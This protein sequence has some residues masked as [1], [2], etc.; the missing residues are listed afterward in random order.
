MN[1]FKTLKIPAALLLTAG[2]VSAT[3]SVAKAD[4]QTDIKIVTTSVKK[5]DKIVAKAD[6]LPD[7]L[8]RVG[9]AIFMADQQQP[10]NIHNYERPRTQWLYESDVLSV[11]DRS[12]INNVTENTHFEMGVDTPLNKSNETVDLGIKDDSPTVSDI[13]KPEAPDVPTV[14]DID[15]P[16]VP[17]VPASPDLPTVSDI[18]KP[19]VPD[20]PV[21][22]DLPTVSD[23]DKPEVP[24][25]PALPDLPTV[26]DIDK[27]EVPDVPTVSDIDKPEVPDVPAL[28]DLPTVSDIDKPE[29]PDVPALPDLPDTPEFPDV[30]TLPDLPDTPEFPDVPTLPDLPDTPDVPTL[31]D[32]PDI[33]EFPDAPTLPDLP[34]TPNVPALPKLPSTPN[35]PDIPDP[36]DVT[37]PATN[38]SSGAPL[39]I[40]SDNVMDKEYREEVITVKQG[41]KTQ[42]D[43]HLKQGETRFVAGNPG[44]IVKIYEDTYYNG[45]FSYSTLLEE[46]TTVEPISDVLYVGSEVKDSNLSVVDLKIGD[47]LDH[48]TITGLEGDIKG[49]VNASYYDLLSE[50]E[51]TRFKKATSSIDASYSTLDPREEEPFNHGYRW[52]GASDDV[53]TLFNSSSLVDK[54][55][56]N[57]YLLNYINADREER[58]L[59]KLVIDPELQ[60]LVDTRAQEM[61]SYGHIHYNGKPHTRPDGTPWSTVLEQL[62]T[63]YKSYGFVENMLAYSVLSNPYQLV[64]EHWIAKR[65]FEQWKSSGPHYAAMM[66][67]KATRTAV[68]VKL[69]TRTNAR[70]ENGTN[71]MVGS[72]LFSK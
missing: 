32:L 36:T 51:D 35:T 11:R 12:E 4:E 19:E 53:V 54:H 42:Y 31:P 46:K 58:G 50:S 41:Q 69:T 26:S 9:Y 40:N 38:P 61:A 39:H 17:D 71:W 63:T 20:V 23:I 66:D 34:E 15:K 57:E 62:P 47:T 16:E 59:N 7:A 6:Y 13:D 55:K 22:P 52:L 60:A 30:P 72:Q 3:L 21:L 48:C 25:T 37:G 45:A 8:G 67:P 18:D 68:S 43:P 1:T 64:S 70:S 65:L 5:K 24:S 44:Q 28:P 2:L 33:P 49:Y 29:A 14:S 56:I 10:E 27:P